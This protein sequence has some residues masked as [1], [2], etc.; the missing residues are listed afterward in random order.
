MPARLRIRKQLE[1]M[2][3]DDLS[4]GA[5]AHPDRHLDY[6]LDFAA[7]SLDDASHVG[8]HAPGLGFE[9]IGSL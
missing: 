5:V 4:S 9:T 2:G 1:P 6:V 3:I 8:E 7:S